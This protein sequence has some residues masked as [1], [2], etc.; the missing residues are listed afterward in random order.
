MIQF[1]ESK[2]KHIQLL[3]RMNRETLKAKRKEMLKNDLSPEIYIYSDENLAYM[4]SFKAVMMSDY[5]ED[6]KQI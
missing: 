1:S 5:V 6:F 3:K 2:K 4:D